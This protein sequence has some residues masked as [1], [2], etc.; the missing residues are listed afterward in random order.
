MNKSSLY[1]LTLAFIFTSCGG[2]GG[3]GSS[4][5]PTPTP[6]NQ[7]PAISSSATFSAAENQTS[8]GSVTA[9]DP[10]GNSLTYS[11]SG[12]EI[13][14]SSTGVLTFASA[15][16]Y[17]TKNSY[18]AT[19]TVSDGS[20]SATQEIT[21][22]ITN[23]N[24]S[25]TI[26]S[27]STFSAE[28]NQTSIGSVIATDPD[29][30]D[31]TYSI[32]GSEINISST[33]VLTF[34]SA[35]DYETKNSYTATVTV[36]DGTLS[37]TQDIEISVSDVEENTAPT[38]SATSLFIDENVT[39]V[40]GLTLADADG[41]TL[42][43]KIEPAASWQA[44][45]KYG[46]GFDDLVFGAGTVDDLDGLET[47][48]LGNEDGT[49]FIISGV[50]LIKFGSIVKLI[51]DIQIADGGQLE[52]NSGTGIY[53][54]DKDNPHKIEVRNGNLLVT[55]SRLRG[56]EI[57]IEESAENPAD[58]SGKV[59]FN[60]V[61]MIKGYLARPSGN[62][63][64]AEWDL[65]SSY[66]EEVNKDSYAYFWYP[67]GINLSANVFY[68]SGPM[69]IGFRSEDIVNGNGSS[70]IQSNIFVR[71]EDVYLNAP[72]NCKDTKVYIC[73]WA[74]Y[75]SRQLALIG[76]V[77]LNT[78]YYAHVDVSDGNTF[79]MTSDDNYYG[80]TNIVNAS[81]RYLDD[82]DD[83]SFNAIKLDDVLTYIDTNA[84]PNF[85]PRLIYNSDGSFKLD[86]PPDYE[87]KQRT[88][89]Y[90]ITFSDGQEEVEEEVT[91][92]INNLAD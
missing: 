87:A 62:A 52:I 86:V 49:P 11:I 45:W 33:G 57:L 25:P 27:S 3:G 58:A 20:L 59:W 70:Y 65:R 78:N 69:T 81:D 12:T 18:T 53:S 63:V 50:T 24:E 47:M 14:I 41:D 72:G 32:S 89:R 82:R 31:L 22:S 21:V 38:I 76:N 85:Q 73:L 66:F 13:N 29:S 15:P 64:Y 48:T 39:S 42:T 68:N 30:D 80:V 4:P 19:V 46:D 5:A 10:D 88:Y 55:G 36:S 23:E 35:P 44:E 26:S 91:L 37:V 90:K 17:E 8:I 56:V 92:E 67:K 9:S 6:S 71:N 61:S 34:A 2:G 84:L 43:V 83:L 75:G 28:E 60:R 1:I 74:A 77:F 7:A 54:E 79:N 40:E 16:D 51:S